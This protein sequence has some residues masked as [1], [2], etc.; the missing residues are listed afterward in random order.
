VVTEDL[1][2]P[3]RATKGLANK[4]RQDEQLVQPKNPLNAPT[5]FH[6]KPHHAR[7]AGCAFLGSRPTQVD[8]FFFDPIGPPATIIIDSGSDITLISEKFLK[9]LNGPPKVRKGQRITLVQVT[10]KSIITGYTSLDL[11]FKTVEG[12]IRISVEAYVVK[13]MTTDFSPRK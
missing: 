7:P 9:T 12:L 6:L 10:G 4:I 5:I 13:G 11:L 2:I 3:T 8:C 1:S